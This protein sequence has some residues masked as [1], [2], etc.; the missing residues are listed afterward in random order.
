[1][2]TA[3]KLAPNLPSAEPF[4]W[5][6]L[7]EL[8]SRHG[9]DVDRLL[10]GVHFAMLLLFVGWISYLVVALWR[11]RAKRNPRANPAGVKTIVFVLVIGIVVVEEAATLFGVAIPLWN[12]NV[13]E[14]PDEKE[15]TVV[16]VTAQQFTWNARYP[17]K[18]G[19]FGAQSRELVS[20]SN[21]LG[22][23][24]GDEA[25]KDD[26]VPPLKDIRVPLEPIDADGDGQ[27]DVDSHG[28]PKFKSVI[29]HL[30]SQDVIHSFKVLPLRI[31]QDAIPGMSIPIH[32]I[33]TRE[34]KYVITCAQL[35]GN[36]HATMIG[37][38]TVMD[39]RPQRAA[40]GTVAAPGAF[41]QWQ[42]AH[43]VGDAPQQSFE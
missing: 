24:P 5:L 18:D 12:K 37:W 33:P 34:G 43:V 21:P 9:E 4:D 13:S 29:I 2:D 26:V 17:G 8:A 20:A 36:G 23:V 6:N 14:Y 38:L 42:A 7:P 1:M 16:R 35:C 15:A 11:F 30:T 27:Q 3:D 10:Q 31:C 28:Q 40:D 41:D 19:K 39:N 25:G 22:Y 32:F